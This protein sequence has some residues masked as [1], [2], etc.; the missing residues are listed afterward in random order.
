M[1]VYVESGRKWIRTGWFWAFVLLVIPNCSFNSHGTCLDCPDPFDPGEQ[2]V[3]SAIACDIPAPFDEGESECATPDEA[4]DENNVSLTEA[5]TALVTGS[6]SMFALDWTQA[7]RDQCGGLPK[8]VKF[9]KPFPDGTFV[10]LNCEQQI[11]AVYSSH[12]AACIAKCKDLFGFGEGRLPPGE[13]D[14]FCSK[15]R[16]ATNFDDNQCYNG[17]CSAGGTPIAFDDPR[18][19]PAPVVWTD[20]WGTD[21]F[22]GSNSLVR[23]S[24]DDFSAG[25]ASEQIIASGDA[26]V[27]FEVTASDRTHIVGIRESR[28]SQGDPCFK[29]ANC[30]DNAPGVDDAGYSI[31]LN[32]QAEVK[33]LET[34]PYGSFGPFWDPYG[35]TERFRV[36]VK[37]NHDGSATVSYIRMTG[38]TEGVFYQS[39]G[40]PKYPLR[41]N[42]TIVEQGATVKD[43]NIVFIK[44]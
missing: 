33:V 42:A 11:P 30:Y 8:K 10:C 4:D 6:N 38:D 40:K 22:G 37:D 9:N 7:A 24:D 44:P 21:D 29:A 16:L 1:R 14:T 17:A 28:D 13:L 19:K 27:E 2:P 25:A 3:S 5:A 39:L 41:V 15:T 34:S 43:V 31:E 32:S 36:R 23:S 26:W 35:A 12:T 18:K 20:K